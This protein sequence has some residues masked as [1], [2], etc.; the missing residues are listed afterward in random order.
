[1]LVHES[2]STHLY[3]EADLL[4]EKVRICNALGVNADGVSKVFVNFFR[5]DLTDE[6]SQYKYSQAPEG[7]TSDIV[8]TDLF[9]G[10]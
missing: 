6:A 4:L 2:G 9:K 7:D 1:M 10:R 5:E 8:Q 3:C